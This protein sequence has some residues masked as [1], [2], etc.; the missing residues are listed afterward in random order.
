M[1]ARRPI[2]ATSL[3]TAHLTQFTRDV[4]FKKSVPFYA[5]LGDGLLSCGRLRGRKVAPSA[6]GE[7]VPYPPHQR[8]LG[9][10]HMD[11]DRESQRAGDGK[12]TIWSKTTSPGNRVSAGIAVQALAH[13]EP[14]GHHRDPAFYWITGL[15]PDWPLCGYPVTNLPALTNTQ[16]NDAGRPTSCPG[17]APQHSDQR[18]SSPAGCSWEQEG[19]RQGL[20][21]AGKWGEGGGRNGRM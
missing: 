4:G 11:T 17:F 2:P 8:A 9:S 5:C 12:I 3:S 13:T 16:S 6:S 7:E 14:R 1:C 18:K 21:E 20:K 19:K 10:G 15:R